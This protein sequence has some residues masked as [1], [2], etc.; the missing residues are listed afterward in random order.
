AI[1][2][3]C[4]HLGISTD[5]MVRRHFDEGE[6]DRF[7][8]N[9]GAWDWGLDIPLED[10][11]AAAERRRIEVSGCEV[12]ALSPAR[13]PDW[14]RSYYE[15]YSSERTPGQWRKLIYGNSTWRKIL[16]ERTPE[17]WRQLYEGSDR[18]PNPDNG[19]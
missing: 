7:Y 16:K 19:A 2:A 6:L 8:E 10:I 17:R 4:D 14:W 5:E 15:G 11:R 9:H 1:V 13:N 12:V 3:H 18:T